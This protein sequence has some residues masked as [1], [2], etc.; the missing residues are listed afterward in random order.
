MDRIAQAAARAAILDSAY[1]DSVNRKVI[2][3]RERVSSS[4][5]ALGFTCLPS[6]ANFIFTK[7]PPPENAARLFAMLRENG[8]LT[9]HFDKP[10]IDAYLRV[11]IGSDSDM[12]K[13][14]EKLRT[15]A[16]QHVTND[17]TCVCIPVAE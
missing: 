16:S 7:P 15:Q 3:T 17:G 8:V 12:D 11:S 10:R 14:M 13:F 2:A 1:Y 4:L 6:S 9:R 5:S